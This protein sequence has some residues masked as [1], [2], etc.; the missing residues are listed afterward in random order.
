MAIKIALLS[1][2][3]GLITSRNS[4]SFFFVFFA[5]TNE[6]EFGCSWSFMQCFLPRPIKVKAGDISS[7]ISSIGS[8]QT[9]P[10]SR[11]GAFSIGLRRGG[12]GGPS[13]AFEPPTTTSSSS[14]GCRSIAHRVIHFFAFFFDGWLGGTG[15]TWSGV[16]LRARAIYEA[17]KN[18][19]GLCC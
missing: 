6:R 3:G 5:R 16:S 11:R 15:R 2:K 10:C 9:Y 17:R 1:S 13:P 19:V 12:S 14:G 7:Y 4:C 18:G 8:R